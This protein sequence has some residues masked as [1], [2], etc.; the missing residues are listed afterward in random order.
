MKFSHLLP[1]LHFVLGRSQVN[2]LVH[3]YL[4]L[5]SE[6]RD[7]AFYQQNISNVDLAVNNRLD[8]FLRSRSMCHR[9]RRLAVFQGRSTDATFSCCCG[10]SGQIGILLRYAKNTFNCHS[11]AIVNRVYTSSVELVDS[12]DHAGELDPFDGVV[13]VEVEVLACD[14]YC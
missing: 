13:E 2:N 6:H 3:P 1:K 5:V 10:N 12:D 14:P 8:I 7:V 11:A 9:R 4:F